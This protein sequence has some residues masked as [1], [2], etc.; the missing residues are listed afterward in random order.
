MTTSNNCDIVNEKVAFAALPEAQR[1]QTCSKNAT[2]NVAALMGSNNIGRAAAANPNSTAITP[3]HRQELL[4]IKL[5]QQHPLVVLLQVP[6]TKVEVEA[7]PTT[8]N[9]PLLQLLTTIIK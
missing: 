9:M 1:H 7:V 6:T 2:S 8:T 5:R 4:Q 3:N